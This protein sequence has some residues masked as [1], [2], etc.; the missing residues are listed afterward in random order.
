MTN[1]SAHIGSVGCLSVSAYDNPSCETN[2]A[3][4]LSPYTTNE[5][6]SRDSSCDDTI[7]FRRCG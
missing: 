1:K 6:F 7:L 2:S 4:I 3:D 5:F